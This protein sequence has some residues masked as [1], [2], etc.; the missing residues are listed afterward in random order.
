MRKISCLFLV[1]WIL[2][3]SVHA[4]AYRSVEDALSWA[5]TQV[6]SNSDQCGSNELGTWTNMCMHFAGHVYGTVPSG[7]NKAILGWTDNGSTFGTR[8][9]TDYES[10]PRGALIFFSEKLISTGHVGVSLGNGKMIHA[11]ISGIEIGW[12]GDLGQF[13]LGWRWPNDWTS[14]TFDSAKLEYRRIGNVAWSPSNRSCLYADRWIFYSQGYPNGAQ[15]ISSS[16]CQQQE[17][18]I[19]MEFGGLFSNWWNMIYSPSNI[20]ENESCSQ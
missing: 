20:V 2:L 11:W 9:T 6:A 16:I 4:H 3:C 14:D 7:F 12:V 5:N 1:C 17:Y 19:M 13:Y 10:I 15:S 8:Y 18:S